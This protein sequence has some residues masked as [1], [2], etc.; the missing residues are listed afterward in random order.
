[1][2]EKESSN[3]V[4][5]EDMRVSVRIG[6]LP[7]EKESPQ[8]LIVSAYAY[9]DEDYLDLA[10]GG[11]FIDYARL[12]DTIAAWEAR[13]H[14]ELLEE[15]AVDLFRAGFAMK[16]VTRMRIRI[17]KADIFEKAVQA[18]IDLTCTRTQWTKKYATL[19]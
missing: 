15:L 16:D 7:F 8:S 4:F 12:H 1:M 11:S 18:G 19:N 5:V 13:A 2:S 9:G 17:G 3:C 6:L 14:T 10:L